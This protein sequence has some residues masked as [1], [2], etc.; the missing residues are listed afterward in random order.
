M[1]ASLIGI[2][3]FSLANRVSG[4]KRFL[5]R[6]VFF[7]LFVFFFF[8]P[9]LVFS[10]T[11]CVSGISINSTAGAI[12]VGSTPS[13]TA[14][15]NTN[16]GL[17]P[18]AITYEWFS[19]IS[20]SNIGGISVQT[21]VTTTN[22][23]SNIY[24]PP[25]TIAG[26]LYY[27]CIV[28]NPGILCATPSF[29]SSPVLVTVSPVL[30]PSISITGNPSGSICAGST[31]VFTAIPVNGG[32]LPSYQWK[33]N[34]SII[35][36]ETGSTFSTNSLLNGEKISVEL[37]S[38]EAC[39]SNTLVSSNELTAVVN[40]ILVPSVI[41]T[42]S[43]AD[44]NIC[45]GSPISF[46]AHPVNG[47]TSPVYQW[48]IDG[49]DVSGAT[50]AS[51]TSAAITNGQKVSVSLVSSETCISAAIVSSNE[52][53]VVVNPILTPSVSISS[54]TG[55]NIC[56]GTSVTF[57]A[58]TVNGGSASYQW[59]RNGINISGATAQTYTTNAIT[60]GQKFS[61]VITSGETCVSANTATSSEITMIV[62][63]V[64]T[65][66]VSISN[67]LTT[68]CPGTAV[69]FTA[70]PVNGGS[71]PIYQWK[72]NG[73]NVGTNNA[74]FLTTSLV[75]GDQVT[76]QL[77]SNGVCANTSPVSN[78][79]A[80]VILRDPIPAQPDIPSGI[81]EVCPGTPN[82]SY[83]IPAVPLATS[84]TWTFPLNWGN[85]TGSATN[86]V[87]V[88]AYGSTSG[89]VTV[90]ARNICGTGPASI[91]P[92]TVNPTTPG[93]P[94]TITGTSSVCPATT[95][96][97]YSTLAVATADVNGYSWMV[98]AGWVITSGQGTTSITATSGVLGENGDVTV[99]SSNSC[100][101]SLVRTFAVTVRNP[102]PATPETPSGSNLV[103]PVSN[104][105]YSIPPV[106]YAT[107]YT[108]SVPTGWSI[109]SGQGT[110]NATIRSGSYGQDGIIS[111][112]ANNSCGVSSAAQ[113][114]VSVK[115]PT[116]V[117][118]VAI[119]GS[120]SVCP[121]INTLI[122]SIADVTNATN[123]SWTVPTGWSIT[124]G[125][126]TTS[127]TVTSGL[128]GQNGSIGVTASN[129]CGTSG[130]R[131]LSVGVIAATPSTPNLITGSSEQ[132]INRTNLVYSI[133]AV[134]NATS[135][136]WTVPA[137]WSITANSTSRT[138][139]LST[140]NTAVS[141]N[142]T[143]TAINS[144]G[145]SNEQILP[146]IVR[147]GAPSN[148]GSPIPAAGQASSICPEA[149]GLIYSIPGVANA[150][151]YI[152]SV[153]TGWTITSGQGTT[154]ITV[155][156]GVQSTGTKTISV[157]ANNSCGSSTAGSWSVTVGTF[158]F[159]SA[160][161][162]QN[163][164]INTTTANLNA[165]VAGA[166]NAANDLTWTASSGSFSNIDK[167][168]PVYTIPASIANSGGSITLT[169][170][171]RAEGSCPSVSDEMV[172]TVLPVP[173]A[174]VNVST[175]ICSGTAA[176]VTFSGTPNT[177]VTYRIGTGS[178]QL[179]NLGATGTAIITTAALTVNTTFQLVS[180]S[181][182]NT[183]ACTN[184]L[185]G[186]ATIVIN[187]I[188]TISASIDQVV[189]AGSPAVTLAGVMGGSATSASW[190]GGN[191]SFSPSASTLNAIY[192]PSN[193][194]IAAGTVTLTL[195][196]NDPAGPCPAVTDQMIITI[197]PSASANASIDQVVCGSNA[198]ITLAGTVGGAAITGSWSGGGGSYAPS[199]NNLNAVYTASAAEILT[200][201]ATLTLTTNDPAGPCA[202][203]TDMVYITINPMVVTNAGAN[204]FACKNSP[205]VTLAG[206]VSGG[207]TTGTWSGGAGTY[208]P[209]A[210]TLNA[211]YTPTASEIAAGS[212][213]LTLTGT[214][215]AGPCTSSS[216]NVLI[217]FNNVVITDAGG[218]HNVC[219]NNP[220]VLLSAAVSGGASTGSWSGGSG[221]FTA[222][223]S[224]LK[225][226]Y[227]PSASEIAAGT[228]TI[229]VTSADPAGPCEATSD[230]LTI[231]IYPAVTIDAGTPQTICS[232][233]TATMLGSVGGGATMGDWY[234]GGS[235][236]FTNYASPNAVYTPSVADIATGSVTL[237]YKSNKIPDISPCRRDTSNIVL[238]IFKNVT[239]GTQPANIAVCA[240]SPANLNV[241]AAGTGLTYQWFKGSYP[242]T[243]VSNTSNISGAATA[244]LHFNQATLA[245][246]GIYYVVVYGL[247]PCGNVISNV[248]TL[249]V[250]QQ[251]SII[252]QPVA[253]TVCQ[254]AATVSFSVSA[255][256]SD[257]LNYQWRRNG[258][259]VGTNSTTLTISPVSLADAGTYNVLISGPGSY[260]CANA[261][262]ASVGLTVTPTVGL[263]VFTAGASTVCQ[264]SPDETYTATAT[265]STS[266]SY[267]VSPSGAGTINPVT[268]TMNW[269]STFTGSATITA[270]ATGCNGPVSFAKVVTV[271]PKPSITS[272]STGIIC[273][274]TAQNFTLTS[275]LP[276]TSY[277]WSRVVVSSISNAA[278]SGQT[279]NPIVE[280]L[281][282]TTST[283]KN[284]VYTIIPT[285]A[286]CA[287]NSINYTVTVN[288]LPTA[289]ISGTTSVCINS[290]SP[291]VVFT[292][293]GGTAPYTFT[294]KI[295]SG[296]NQT[297]T[298]L[299]GNSVAI[300]APTG[301]TGSFTYSLV[302]VREGSANT[303]NQSQTG[304]AIISILPN[305]TI[306]RSS[307]SATAAQSVCIN[308]PVSSITYSLGGGAT[309]ATI[310]G[311]PAGVT[312]SVSGG[313]VTISGTPTISGVY[314]YNVQT[315][316]TCLPASLGGS[317]TVNPMPV[318]GTTTSSTNL[319]ACAGS[320]GGNVS[321]TGQVGTVSKW[322]SSTDAGVTWTDIAN[323]TAFLSYINLNQ[324]TWYRAAIGQATCTGAIAYSAHTVISVVPTVGAGSLTGT[325]F[326]TTIC[327]GSSKLTATGNGVAGTTG[328]LTGGSFDLAGEPL[329]GAGLWRAHETGSLHN[330][331]GSA[332]NGVNPFNLTNGPK[333]F[334]QGESGAVIYNNNPLGG[335][336][337]NNKFMVANGPV[338][339]TLE[340][341]IF[342]LVGVTSAS[343]DWWEAYILQSGASIRMEISTNGGNSYSGLARP[344]VNGPA[345]NGIPTNFVKASLDLSLYKGMSNLRVR[346]T[347]TGTQY[348]SWGIEMATL[349][350]GVA[351][352]TY[353][354]N[355]YY[356]APAIG[357][358]PAHYLNVFTDTSVTVTPPTPNTT[359]APIPYYYSLTS[360]TG[361]CVSNIIVTVNPTPV[362]THSAVPTVCSGTTLSPNITFSS[363]IASTTYAFT[364]TNPGG[365]TGLITN[366]NGTISGT[367]VN[368]TSTP[369]TVTFIVSPVSPYCP[370]IP[371]TVRLVVPPRITVTLSG[372]QSICPGSGSVVTL[373]SA[374]P[375][376]INVTLSN[377][378]TYNMLSSP[379][380]ITLYPAATTNFS[381]TSLGVT[382]CATA[383]GIAG[384]AAITVITPPVISHSAVG[385][386]CSGTA[387]SPIT[388]SSSTGSTSYSFVV[389]N[390]GGVT[391]LV[392]NSNGTISGTPVNLS[393]IP[394]TVTFVVTGTFSGCSGS[395]DIVS[396][397]INPVSTIT[398]SG[399]QT[400]CAAGSNAILTLSASGPFPV[401]VSLS[402][403]QTY[404][405]GSSPLNITVNPV[406][407]TNYT[408]SSLN[409]TCISNAGS[410]GN[411]AV[412]VVGYTA[413]I[414][415]TWNCGAGDGDWFNPCNWANGIVPDTS[416]NVV[417][418]TS[419]SSCNPVINPLTSF[420]AIH[421]PVAKSKNITIDGT[422]NLSFANGGELQVAGNWVNNVGVTG[423]TANTGTV[424]M[425]GAV[426]QTIATS[427][428]SETFYRLGISNRSVVTSGVTLLS[429]IRVTNI[430]T[431]T[432]GIVNTHSNPPTS[433][434]LAA[435]NSFGLLT[436]TATANPVAG[437]PGVGSFINGQMAR[438]F[439]TSGVSSEYAYPIGKVINGLP[440]YKD[441]AVQPTTTSGTTTFT[442]EYFPTA[443]PT[444]SLMLGTGLAGIVPEYWQVDQSGGTA[445][446]RVK[447]PYLNPGT[448]NW[449]TNN[450]DPGLNPCTFC[451]VAVV[452]KDQ[453]SNGWNF[454][455][456]AGNFNSTD[457]EYRFHLDMGYI[458]SR[459]NTAFGPFTNGYAISI[460]LPV[461]ILSFDAKL[462]NGEGLVSWTIA[463]NTDL[464]IFELQHSSTDG[465]FKKLAMV[466]GKDK[467]TRYNF[468]HRSMS[469]GENY[470]RLLV[471]EK[472]GKSFYSKTILL[473]A[474]KDKTEIVGLQPT[475]VVNETFIKVISVATQQARADVFDITG[476]RVGSYKTNLAPGS[477]KFL[478]TA[479]HLAKG[480][481]T[482]QVETSDGVKANLRFMKE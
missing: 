131:T 474:G 265:N 241:V 61:V 164:C 122:Y 264:D 145:I 127:V 268:G 262:S 72:L 413:G 345:T 322:Q 161:V 206:S 300:N 375:F 419:S 23:T 22:T 333:E 35:P 260:A 251:I 432:S 101:T 349:K 222:G 142:I 482:V 293:A 451:N 394:Q 172:I 242:G 20:N 93:R 352:A 261:T 356:P 323:T 316:G 309:G 367:P 148:P 306:T 158:P 418:A 370:G 190:T 114:S 207:S 167:A 75:S 173:T 51:F 426:H 463:G 470:Y 120:T 433:P 249:S 449:I 25:T 294:Y 192:T 254:G 362:I 377:G 78:I 364:V 452:R 259:N 319:F 468:L 134:T 337:N 81:T 271:N 87:T 96:F 325:A 240:T 91:L 62:N 100:G 186:S 31:V 430:L 388:F 178:N 275:S 450:N 357:T 201:H 258:V 126:G 424:T 125:Q 383:G 58:I 218:D 185:T 155:N 162:D 203:V 229:T 116:P 153:P 193:D 343:L 29:I 341:P 421:G 296:S 479:S 328:V 276:S 410:T 34:N 278:V 57:S 390:P 464:D 320:N 301:S 21:T 326:P 281:I 74:A 384:G 10:Q 54:N 160:N 416:I 467:E 472:T 67:P 208:F 279:A 159:V 225:P 272:G 53:T 480:I 302:S 358:P 411:A 285:A 256:A 334:F 412:S 220:E 184:L 431:L 5:N 308:S 248:A 373:T 89:N 381:I 154:S 56:A 307:A 205:E 108:W 83:S 104:T 335:E 214:D 289:A 18:G 32:L 339:S 109:V 133:A 102:V 385:S 171:A 187:P 66:S 284:V 359:N 28:S 94:S 425:V 299:G 346:F 329:E 407:T 65:P 233:S 221:I 9:S 461:Q 86:N 252:T 202:P 26:S 441:M 369:Q 165:L 123:Y 36:G 182:T 147:T 59:K 457:P 199:N 237:Y 97:T 151:S 166:T 244:N 179:I 7:Q 311:L 429:D 324:T 110:A 98:P 448:G 361:G 269:S 30:T 135:Y 149:V 303:C 473:N 321:L 111:I 183:P 471:R 462:V 70:N 476:R 204:L 14:T 170:S 2:S 236:V 481:Y 106:L 6:F 340:T 273:S 428:I 374:G 422:R 143:V 435:A 440:V 68:I 136:A 318:G 209:D 191:G 141:G 437:N 263:P 313:I 52:I 366:S 414:T 246:D 228:A 11:T 69:T 365:V 469:P 291:Q 446:A 128:T 283:S 115:P 404:V 292:G 8:N 477:N 47:G 177:T 255:T 42:S 401:N 73:N 344:D 372:N 353:T 132:C 3:H 212:L 331:E 37:A 402:N 137:G 79:A 305:G 90:A 409:G 194:E 400:I 124:A 121:G 77:V 197:N 417:I 380:N 17:L 82:L 16:A 103:C 15:I 351:P 368:P 371:D 455:S 211:V 415:G 310:T 434:L 85:T 140:S 376:P 46:T 314:N 274:G 19:N 444:P 219:S 45:A 27:Y 226:Y 315:S 230:N 213:T 336:V 396:L 198:V 169:V 466:K 157:I 4:I 234:T 50:N 139:T 200:G 189:C 76:V 253:R 150:S 442:S 397:V 250:D 80:N 239:I 55:N 391:G 176:T 392:T 231:V 445:D 312:T 360:S 355:L 43:D 478:V 298:T 295:N 427:G 332:N 168:N 39:I 44:N 181:Y 1:N 267:S 227:L 175:P 348:S 363:N 245:D 38:N 454:T 290:S 41:I 420:A 215:P 24:N 288:A 119:F 386:V 40:P 458:Y 465:V 443:H 84:Y 163:F 117:A 60:N 92:I 217:T 342:S 286:G 436:M 266:I 112:T 196:T 354:W 71:A 33:L 48:K 347:Y 330:I 257:P 224:S 188:A 144:C 456:T 235:G 129:S 223:T 280:S 113:I 395:N 174:T 350:L 195:S 393:A 63:P 379:M 13:L 130:N 399:S 389:S 447:I 287:G 105:V 107:G 387:L 270:T 216:D 277:T 95:G 460:I 453:G 405:M 282:N 317:I 88:F 247:A 406:V 118:P 439:N 243:A 138:V 238:T 99:T 12:C 438:E 152:W 327:T 232:G 459:S 475:A 156:A 49:V 423:F 180:T 398:I 382:S 210:T 64:L 403:G 297:I 304:S 408:I 338:H 146:V 378:T